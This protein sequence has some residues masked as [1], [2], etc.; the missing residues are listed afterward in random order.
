MALT[1][2]ATTDTQIIRVVEALYNQTPGY[3]YLANFRTFTADNGIDG[4][5]NALAA[6]FAS[7]TDAALA[8]TVTANLGLTGD[9]LTAGNAYLEAQFAADAAGRGKAVLDAMNALATLGNDAVYGAA[10]T[11]FNAEVVASTTYSMVATNTTPLAVGAGQSYNLTTAVDN[12]TGTAGDDSFY[13]S[14]ATANAAGQTFSSADAVNG[15]E[16]ADSLTASIGAAGTYGTSGV[17]NVETMSGT[18]TA[19]GTVSLQGNTGITTVESQSSTNAAAFNNI[20]TAA[21]NLKASNTAF[22]TTF[23]FV[24]S[25]LTGTADTANLTLNG[26]TAGTVD[27][28]T[29]AAAN[30]FETI[31]INSTGSA[32][33]ATLGDTNQTSVKTINVTGDQ[34]LALTTT[35]VTTYTTVDASAMTGALTLTT[36]N[37]GTA[38]TVTG[39]TGNDGITLGAAA[40]A[41]S[42]DAGAGDDTI[43]FSANLTN[44]DTIN[45]GDGT[46]ILAGVAANLVSSAYAKP[47]TATVTNIETINVTDLLDTGNY[48]LS[49]IASGITTFGMAAG[50]DNTQRT[51]TFEGGGASNTVNLTGTTV[52]GTSGIKFAAAGTNT[53]DSLTINQKSTTALFD[54]AGAGEP[55]AVDG[56]ET[57]AINNSAVADTIAGITLTNT[58]AAAQTVNF[59]GAF[60]MTVGTITPTTGTLAAVDASGM[61]V[62]ATALG[63]SATAGAK[64]AMTGSGGRDS[65]T[66]SS[67]ID[68]IDGGAG[69]D[70]IAAG[71]GND[72]ITGGE[73]VD[74]ITQAGTGTTT[75]IDAGAGNDT[76]TMSGKL[77]ST[78]T[79]NGGEGTDTLVLN[80][81]DVTTLNALSTANKA[82]MKGNITGV[83][84]V[85]FAA[86]TGATMD[87]STMFNTA[88]VN[89]VKFAAAQTSTL[90]NLAS[91]TTLEYTTAT[92]TGTVSVASA[93]TGA[94]DVLNMKYT[95]AANTDF[96]TQT[97]ASIETVNINS[98]DADA[99]TD[100]AET[101]TVTI[102]ADSILGGMAIDGNNNLVV[103]T[104]GATKLAT[105]DASSLTGTLNANISASTATTTVTLGSG[106]STISGGSGIDNVVGGVG[107]DSIT[108]N[109]GA[110]IIDGGAGN[111]TITGGS[112]ADSLTG[113]SGNDVFSTSGGG[114]DTID[115]GAGTDSL[116]IAN[117][118]YADISALSTTSLETL[119]M[120]SQA[121]TMTVAQ[122]GGF[123]TWANTAAVTFSDAGTIAGRSSAPLTL[124]LANGTNTFTASTTAADNVVTGG[125]GADT[126]N[127]G[128]AK[129]TAGDVIAG[130]T[131]TDT[132][133]ITGNT[134]YTVTMASGM[135]G[136][137]RINISNTTTNVS[138]TTDDAQV[139]AGQTLTIDGGSLTTGT[140]TVVGGAE[141]SGATAIINVIGGSAGDTITTGSGADTIT[142]GE[143][144]DTIT[145]GAGADNVILTEAVAAADTVVLTGAASSTTS[146]DIDNVIT[147]FGTADIID[148]TTNSAFKHGVAANTAYG[149]EGVVGSIANLVGLQVFSNNIAVAD[150][151]AGPTEAEMETYVG[152]NDMFFVGNVNDEV[153]VVADNGA[154]TY[155]MQL[156]SSGADNKV[157]T[158]AEDVGVVLAVLVGVTDATT[159]SA[160]N[161][162]DFS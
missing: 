1:L 117:S 51:V 20:S 27:I 127:L 73:G 71:G 139:V 87:M 39:G 151:A 111:D 33:T 36:T 41:D 68:T 146:T 54:G 76:I 136:L 61:T 102:S 94:A 122:F 65:L 58:M 161:F 43:T 104:S 97:V 147:G 74:S 131:G 130:G 56:Y 107:N 17:S 5:A 160:A 150:A 70:T 79:I 137:E 145:G 157:F 42:I 128:S 45:G 7:S 154:N 110:D 115:G 126:F 142:G 18:F 85:Q 6:D 114:S 141:T 134:A 162:A 28:A 50:S 10:A 96:G 108:G 153:Y 15:G 144:A 81:T 80:A 140:L 103:T 100:A 57:I 3:T 120:N 31:A 156:G 63:L 125:T 95:K 91:G 48:T 99:A 90:N 93:A 67:G 52:I 9:A 101:H 13:A 2:L 59:T 22:G 82:V 106:N 23:T 69:N 26:M 53:S 77:A 119:D 155:I 40:V 92:S 98:A 66:G 159:L 34:N 62:A 55:L 49:N 86:N 135:T 109:S 83:E 132:L 121:T 148:L 75:N 158:E 30:G 78:Q 64:T 12:L 4:F 38:T 113:G 138:L 72:V 118:L 88:E 116:Q 143:G 16:G 149:T 89:K 8:A 46:D 105:V 112:S 84:T 129:F 47:T 152:V 29:A 123:T 124:N 60:G 24:D 19:G 32:N 14:N 25:A 44:A 11:A 21:M 35:A 37:A 133:N